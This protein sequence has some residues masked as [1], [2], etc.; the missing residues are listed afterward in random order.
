MRLRAVTF[1]RRRCLLLLSLLLGACGAESAPARPEPSEDRTRDIQS[2][3]LAI[4]LATKTG[5]ATIQLQ[6]SQSTGASFE[7]GDLSVTDVYDETGPLHYQI[8]G[9]RLD[10]GVPA[11]GRLSVDYGFREYPNFTGAMLN[12]TFIW[13]YYCGN[14]FPCKSD[15]SDG[16]RFTLHLTGVADGMTAV[17]P[18]AIPADAPSYQ[19]AWAIGDYTYLEVGT[20]A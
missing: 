14:L 19:I 17:Y 2:T 7:I 6:P 18:K 12:T 20:T 5:T 11:S 10:V 3:D 1:V 15:P 13:P 8:D 9:K 4:D 16:L